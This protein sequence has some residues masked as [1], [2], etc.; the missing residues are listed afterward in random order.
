MSD[1]NDHIHFTT[2]DCRRW[3]QEL[4]DSLDKVKTEQGED[5]YRKACAACFL[6][7]AFADTL[8]SGEADDV[9]MKEEDL[10]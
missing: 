9:V 10:N 7:Q 4:H 3:A 5:A 2:E 6:F 8:D 1:D